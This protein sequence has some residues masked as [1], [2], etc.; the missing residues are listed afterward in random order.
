[1]KKSI[2]LRSLVAIN[3][4]GIIVVLI[5]VLSSAIS[6]R[7]VEGYKNQIGDTLS[8]ISYQMADKLDHYM[9]ARYRELALL[10]KIDTFTNLDNEED[11]RNLINELQE[12]A[13]E[14]AWI[15][16]LDPEGNVDISTG[17]ILEGK[18]IAARPVYNKAIENPFIGDVHEAVLLANL[19]PNPTGEEMKFVDIS[20]PIKDENGDLKCILATHLS[21]KWAEE[22]QDSIMKPLKNRSELELFIISND[23]TVLLGQNKFL[24]QKMELNSINNSR[25]EENNWIVEKWQD[26][27]EYLVGYSKENGYKNYEGLGWT[28]LVTQPLDIAYEPVENLSNF[29]MLIGFIV[30]PIFAFLGWIAAGTISKPLN[31]IVI[32]SEKLKED[33]TVEIP[34]YKGIKDIELLSSSL[35]SLIGSLINTEYALGEMKG[36]AHHDQLTGLKN[37][38][39][40]VRYFE[41]I[42]LKTLNDNINYIIYYL[43]LDGFKSINDNYGHD[44][45]D[46]MLKEVAKRLDI[47]TSKDIFVS[48]LGGDEFII[49]KKSNSDEY[50]SESI[51]FA[52][53]LIEEISKPYIIEG[54]VMKIGCS[55]GGAFYPIQGENPIDVMKLAD[56]YLYKSKTTGKNKYTYLEKNI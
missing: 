35:K 50:I 42:K 3:I 27:K 41:K 19:L 51:D 4:T 1:M 52:N 55:I 47:N 53:M 18:N 43:D 32:A 7:A 40:L 26:G 24:G 21:W 46:L 13:P 17:R 31:K 54:K 37:R 16:I 49:I 25:D 34:E 9:W 45:G 14:Y 5:V 56:E 33:K 8:E 10:S 15:G 2:S 38:E 28:I 20:I 39:A 44:S 30:A 36:I 11:I 29:V 48:R 22:I 23:N 6:I 12:N